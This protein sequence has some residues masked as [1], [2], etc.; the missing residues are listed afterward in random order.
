MV[1]Q[2]PSADWLA[3]DPAQYTNRLA[4][5]SGQIDAV[6]PD[7][8]R[9]KASGGKLIL[10]TGLTDWL[11]TAN[12]ATDYYQKVVTASGGQA[13]A[14]EFVEYFTAP[15]VSHCSNAVGNGQ[16]ADTVNLLGPMFDWIEKGVKPSSTGIVATQSNPL[17]GQTAKQRPL[18]K[19]PQYAKYN[20]TGDANA[21]A[22]FSC[23]TP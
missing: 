19:F 14:D 1:T 3:V 10:W 13:T 8:S 18:C 4:L 23:V 11:I 17:T 20:G 6:N 12:N 16:G 5:L 15:G 21:A 9:F 22:S 2:N 7:L